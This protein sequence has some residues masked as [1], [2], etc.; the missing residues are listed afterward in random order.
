AHGWNPIGSHQLNLQLAPGAEETFSCVLGYVEQG[1]ENKFEAP[2]VMNKSK[3]RAVMEKYADNAAV[4]AAFDG[5]KAH[6]EELLG[7]FQIETASEIMNR[8]ANTWNQVQC[9]AT[10]NLSRSASMFESGIGRG[11]GYRDSNQ[12]LLGF[13]HLVPEKARQRV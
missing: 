8:M 12:D 2:F 7:R 9:M 13:V 6:W 1:S 3:G 10:F 5:V 4:N 11:M